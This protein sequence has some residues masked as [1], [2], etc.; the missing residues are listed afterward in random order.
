MI[1]LVDGV[2]LT[3]GDDGWS[4]RAPLGW[5]AYLRAFGYDPAGKMYGLLWISGDPSSTVLLDFHEP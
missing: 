2:F 4:T 5:G 1:G 3:R